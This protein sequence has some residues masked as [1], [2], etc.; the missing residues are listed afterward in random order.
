MRLGID[1]GTTRIVVAAV[2]RGNYPV[3]QFETPDGVTADWFPPL[4]AVRGKE[5]RYGWDA[6]SL[7]SEPGWTIV[8]SLKRLLRNAGPATE[9][10]IAEQSLPMQLLLDEITAQLRTEILERSTLSSS[11][12][13]QL[14]I[15]LGVPANANS[16]QRFLEVEAFRRGGFDVLGL[17]N[18]PSAASIEFSHYHRTS[19]NGNNDGVLLV[20]DLGGG[21]FDASVVELGE[22]SHVVLG[23]EGIVTLGGD[24]FDEILAEVALAQAGI[25]PEELDS[26]TQAELFRLHEECRQKKE[27]LHPNSRKIVVDLSCAREGWGEFS[28]SVADYYEACRPLVEETLHAVEYLL[29]RHNLTATDGGSGRQQTDRIEAV[30]V[31]GGGSELP[32]VPRMLR[33]RFGRRVRRSTHART[34]TAIGLAIQADAAAGYH[35]RDRF[36]RY[37][38]VWRE[39]DEGSRIAFDPLFSKEEALPAAG[40][41]PLS[42]ERR[43]SPVHNIGH[44][45]YLESSHITP[46]GQP[47][48]DITFWDEIRFPFDPSLE[49]DPELGVLAV[50]L[51]EEASRQAVQEAYSCDAGGVLTL[52]ITNETDGHSRRFQLGRWA[53]TNKPLRPGRESRRKAQAATKARH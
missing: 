28:L 31:A 29:E 16:N 53:G 46:D 38:G 20:Y 32:L 26:L 48:G 39:A 8:R 11:P 27:T 42:I 2:D 19:S 35:V 52:T 7:Q 34:T 33:D 25:A 22:K 24:D 41:Q 30:Y 1:F 14:E 21:T 12:G 23:S 47:S 36:T 5:R 17:L 9:V 15:Y 18:E 44:F 13:E 4:I 10:E 49:D 51:S 37:F 50:R 45:R 43:Y 6:W 3:A 40:E